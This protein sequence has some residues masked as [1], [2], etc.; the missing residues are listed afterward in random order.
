MIL[1]KRLLQNKKSATHL[2]GVIVYHHSFPWQKCLGFTK[3]W[4]TSLNPVDL[5][6]L[7]KDVVRTKQGNPVGQCLEL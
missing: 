7:S 6:L 3:Q 2:G 1:I 4:W 5:F